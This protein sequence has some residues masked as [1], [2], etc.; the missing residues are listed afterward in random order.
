M[1]VLSGVRVLDL[2]RYIAGPHCGSVLG[3]LGADVVKVER[4]RI[5]DDTRAF[6]PSINGESAYFLA[7]NRSK[8]GITLDFRNPEAQ[9]ILRRLAA[10]ADILIENFRPGTME[11][12]G[13]GWDALHKINPRLIMARISGYGQNTSRANEPCFDGIAQA[14]SG[15]MD[16]TGERD[17]RPMMAGTFVVDYA[18]ALYAAIGILGV[19]YERATTGQGRM[20][21]VSLM[22][23]ATSLLMTAIPEAA[24]LGM[25]RTR[26]GNRDRYA[27]PANT[28]QA[29]D[30]AWVHIMAGGDA[31]FR[32]FAQVMG[33]PELIDDPRFSTLVA[34]MANV[35]AIEAV[36]ASWISELA[37]DE[38][39]DR[40]A[41]AELPAAKIATIADLIA[42]PFMREA[43][44]IID[45]EH[46]T[47]GTVPLSG[48]VVRVGDG[49]EPPRPAPLLG[50]HTAEIMQ[51]WLAL[52]DAEISRLKHSNVF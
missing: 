27:A 26:D 35:D 7:F 52:P 11:K 4:A 45:V 46:P 49:D 18:T 6:A 50:Q 12:M 20:V 8:R 43:G 37:A 5:G 40:M 28:F 17:G 14:T 42:D 16:L 23:S 34:R 51:E 24:R 33:R 41:A 22:S 25:S 9:E 48:P 29:S 21:D 13:C 38:V 31:P 15:L 19:L 30:G 3:D 1:P 32:R 44:N 2:S 10:E 47:A 39:V 36:A